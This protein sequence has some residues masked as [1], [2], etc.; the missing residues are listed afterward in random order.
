MQKRRRTEFN[1]I[2]E[3]NNAINITIIRISYINV[4]QNINTY[5]SYTK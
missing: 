5:Y 3:A 4:R 2:T 1:C